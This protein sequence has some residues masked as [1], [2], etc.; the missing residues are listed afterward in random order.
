MERQVE[1]PALRSWNRYAVAPPFGLIEEETEAVVAVRLP[2]R[3]GLTVG[4]RMVSVAPMSLPA[5][6]GRG[7]P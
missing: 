5:P 6:M 1:A 7:R 2:A 3:A 4:G